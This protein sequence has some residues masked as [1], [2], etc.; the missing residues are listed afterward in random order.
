M[1][2]LSCTSS[3]QMLTP[4]HK[5]KQMK[6]GYHQ[7]YSHQLIIS[8]HHTID[9]GTLRTTHPR[10]EVLQLQ[11]RGSFTFNNI[12]LLYIFLY[13][14]EVIQFWLF[15]TGNQNNKIIKT[16]WTNVLTNHLQRIDKNV[17]MPSRMC[18]N[19]I[20]RPLYTCMLDIN[21]QDQLCFLI[22]N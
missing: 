5:F 8:E 7:I 9:T 14:R 1:Q 19:D 21:E 11:T 10:T 15:P 6:N 12:S 22:N 17:R 13:L 16:N 2:D 20:T 4:V 3:T 18:I